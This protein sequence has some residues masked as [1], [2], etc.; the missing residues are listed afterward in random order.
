MQTTQDA[1]A[2][3]LSS[4]E[5]A[6]HHRFSHSSHDEGHL[7]RS[8]ER[9][10]DAHA[11]F[12][13]AATL[14]TSIRKDVIADLA[15]HLD[16]FSGKWNPL[17]FLVW[18][19]GV[20]AEGNSL[21]LH[22][23][24][25]AARKVSTFAPGVHCHAW[26]LSSLMVAGGYVDV[27]YNVVEHGYYSEEERARQGLLRKFSLTYLPTGESTL[28]NR[29]ECVALSVRDVH[30]VEAGQV[31]HIKDG[32]FHATLVP[33][34]SD[35]V[36]LVLDSPQLGYNT[37]TVLDCGPQFPTRGRE[38]ASRDETAYVRR[39]LADLANA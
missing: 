4:A 37:T 3:A 28:V 1:I 27:H 14:L 20:D 2:P 18:H 11:Y 39:L 16:E 24:P 10:P 35:T 7:L 17:G 5:E 26:Y 32:V 31:H 9:R 33:R 6:W 19:L 23:W 34:A 29:G 15:C 38:F 12:A 13:G 22:V 30:P 36:T 25:R 8:L 21:R